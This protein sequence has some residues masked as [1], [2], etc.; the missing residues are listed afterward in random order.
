MKKNIN[1]AAI[2]LIFS[3]A[4]IYFFWG[5]RLPVSGG[6][7]WDGLT[8]AAYAKDFIHEI[9]TNADLYHVSRCFPSLLIWLTTKLFHLSLDSPRDIFNAFFIFNAL[10]FMLIAYLWG[11]I[12]GL[13]H[14]S[15]AT[16]LFGF[17]CFFCNF[18]FLKYYFYAP[19]VTDIFALLLG[20]CS[21]YFYLKKSIIGLN[22]L[23][24]PTLLTWPI[25]LVFISILIFF[26]KPLSECIN[27]NPSSAL[28]APSPLR[29]EGKNRGFSLLPSEERRMRVVAWTVAL[30]YG[31]S[32]FLLS[33]FSLTTHL[34]QAAGT[35]ISTKLALLSAILVGIYVF[36]IMDSIQPSLFLKSIR[37]FNKTNLLIYLPF[38]ALTLATHYFLK[39]LSPNHLLSESS[40]KILNF[41]LFYIP[42]APLIKPGL[43]FTMF[44]V[45]WG[46]M[47]FL[48]ILKCREMFIK[49]FAE[50]SALAMLLLISFYF[51]LNPQC[52]FDTFLIPLTIYS[53][54]LVMQNL[55]INLRF[56]FAYLLISLYC[57]KFYY[58]L[59]SGYIPIQPTGEQLYTTGLQRFFMNTGY[60]VSWEGYLLTLLITLMTGLMMLVLLR[61]FMPRSTVSNPPF[62]Y[63]IPAA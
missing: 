6:L 50:G 49:A 34:W 56:C 63:R 19:V 2:L 22:L 46:P 43:F 13:K 27:D 31:L 17:L 25:G 15:I 40:P 11:K 7:G 59:N 23:L 21:L 8:Y 37:D 26:D 54:S 42:T 24:I 47:A 57:S 51:L 58:S 29:G 33:R 32:L 61:R 28:R 60:W 16:Q 45:N 53:L 4:L 48:V 62:Q 18:V 14:F 1:P 30:G 38:L 39:S 3:Y 20:M 5:E 36:R 35:Q 55:K 10:C 12:V 9:S 52:R 41:F 44:A